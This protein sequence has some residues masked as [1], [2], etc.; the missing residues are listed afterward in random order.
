MSQRLLRTLHLTAN[1]CDVEVGR[2]E[3]GREET[4]DERWK[5]VSDERASG[6]KRSA[7]LQCSQAVHHP[8]GF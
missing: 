5:E 3:D 7:G 4:G 1:V 8:K 6:G 2:E